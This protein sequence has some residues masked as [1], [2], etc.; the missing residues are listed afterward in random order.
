M[1]LSLS[2]LVALALLCAT[3]VC[4]RGDTGNGKPCAPGDG[5]N[6][7]SNLLPDEGG[8]SGGKPLSGGHDGTGNFS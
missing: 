3:T 4:L 2:K 7:G 5:G 8:G 6:A 1:K